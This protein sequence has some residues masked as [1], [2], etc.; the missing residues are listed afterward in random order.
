MD[1]IQDLPDFS[2]MYTSAMDSVN[3]INAGSDAFTGDDFEDALE[4]NKAH[5]SYILEKYEWSPEFDLS[6]L[7]DARDYVHN[8]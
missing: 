8:V 2:K 6:P 5:L 7:E 1:N 3:F 4:R